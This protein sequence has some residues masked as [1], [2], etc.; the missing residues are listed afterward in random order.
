MSN[1]K[2]TVI[3]TEADRNTV[4][5]AR[6]YYEKKHKK[7][8]EMSNIVQYICLI[9]ALFF[10]IPIILITTYF[11]MEMSKSFINM[12]EL[13]LIVFIISWSISLFLEYKM[14]MYETLF[15]E[16][17]KMVKVMDIILQDREYELKAS[18][19]GSI[20][21]NVL[22][23][24][25][26]TDSMTIAQVQTERPLWLNVSEIE[27]KFEQT[28]NKKHEITCSWQVKPVKWY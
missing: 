21:I 8:E 5:N 25:K 19:S 23:D 27:M 4:D 7:Y 15:E 18:E 2:F 28:Y 9:S 1:S 3:F 12:M 11:K 24:S 26:I 13:A 20:W 10:I 14:S 22:D 16:H 17:S 6:Q